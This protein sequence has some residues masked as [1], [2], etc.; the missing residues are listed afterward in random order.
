VRTLRPNLNLV[1]KFVSN[2]LLVPW[3][4]V[5]DCGAG[6]W[7]VTCGTRFVRHWC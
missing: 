5:G 4:W 2:D 1:F 6:E 3:G 7:T